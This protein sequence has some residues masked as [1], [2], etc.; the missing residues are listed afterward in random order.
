MG[1]DGNDEGNKK[2]CN[3]QQQ[4]MH[5]KIP[6]GPILIKIKTT[7]YKESEEEKPRKMSRSSWVTKRGA[8]K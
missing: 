1:S 2:R 8:N 6:K 7:G 4:K 3:D 5:L